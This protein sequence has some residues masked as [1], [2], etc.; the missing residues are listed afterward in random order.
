MC[1][2]YHVYISSFLERASSNMPGVI[3]LHTA[4]RAFWVGAGLGFL[5]V[6]TSFL[7]PLKMMAKIDGPRLPVSLGRLLGMVF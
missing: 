1:V 4:N 3:L 6:Q 7:R 5:A 2:V